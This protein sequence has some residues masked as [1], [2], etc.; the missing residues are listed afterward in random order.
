MQHMSDQQLQEH[1][2]LMWAN[3]IE[4]GDV[5][6]SASDLH[7]MGRAQQAKS[8][9]DSQRAFVLRLRQLAKNQRPA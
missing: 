3:H 7:A 6:L 4:T 9:S 1:S 8:L 2:L 5:T